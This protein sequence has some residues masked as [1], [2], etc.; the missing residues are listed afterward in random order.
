MEANPP[1]GDGLSAL[2]KRGNLISEE[3]QRQARK[4]ASPVVNDFLIAARRGF[5]AQ[6]LLALK[7]GG[8]AKVNSVDKVGNGGAGRGGNGP[9]SNCTIISQRED[10]D[11]LP[12]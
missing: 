10:S 3:I 8:A 2:N 7:E 12:L 5:T 9:S 1:P 11:E 6:V 4:A